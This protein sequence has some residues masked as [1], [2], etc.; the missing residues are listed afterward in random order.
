MLVIPHTGG[1][2]VSNVSFCE[3]LSNYLDLALLSCLLP[4]IPKDILTGMM[5]GLT[6]DRA[7][8]ISINYVS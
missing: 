7:N 1:L 3:L 4:M 2:R 6:E 8:T 5:S